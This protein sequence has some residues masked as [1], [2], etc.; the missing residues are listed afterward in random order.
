M[1]IDVE[2]VMS[3]INRGNTHEECKPA[4]IENQMMRMIKQPHPLGNIILAGNYT[5]QK[6]QYFAENYPKG[7][8]I[9]SKIDRK[10]FKNRSIR[11]KRYRKI[12]TSPPMVQTQ[13]HDREAVLASGFF[14]ILVDAAVDA[15]SAIHF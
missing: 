13:Y 3:W 1:T 12:Y 15:K 2:S 8:N 11:K 9:I 10:I 14:Y 6:L 7:A 4:D 5:M